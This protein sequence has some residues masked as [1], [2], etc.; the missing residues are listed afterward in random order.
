MEE[1]PLTTGKL[2]TRKLDGTEKRLGGTI[3]TEAHK[4]FC[5]SI[6]ARDGFEK[7]FR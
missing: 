7:L 3:A 1:T 5:P 2:A 6:Y 4:A